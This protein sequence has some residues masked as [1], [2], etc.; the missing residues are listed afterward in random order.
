MKAG[1]LI[2]ASLIAVDG[3]TVKCDG[4]NMRDMGDGG[5]FVSGYDTPEIY[6]PKCQQELELARA[7]KARMAELLRTPGVEVVYSGKKDKTPSHRP[8]VWVRLPDG[9][10][11]GSILISEGLARK[12]TPRHTADWCD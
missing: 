8:L 5:P 4:V 2:C 9:R 11:I 3:D 6:H 10:S 1:L 12:W 7:A